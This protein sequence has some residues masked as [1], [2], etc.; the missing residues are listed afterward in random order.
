MKQKEA[1]KYRQMWVYT[2][3]VRVYLTFSLHWE[4]AM[5]RR[6][7]KKKAGSFLLNST[8]REDSLIMHFGFAVQANQQWIRA[9][10]NGQ[11]PET[12]GSLWLKWQSLKW[13]SLKC[14]NGCFFF[15]FLFSSFREIQNGCMPDWAV[16]SS[17]ND[18]QRDREKRNSLWVSGNWIIA[19]F[20]QA[21]MET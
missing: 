3:N 2:R 13:M 15:F 12:L 14:A 6:G 20:T 1:T 9:M 16:L 21:L 19:A 18:R 11:T 5:R 7:E 17:E 10:M 8:Q 4:K